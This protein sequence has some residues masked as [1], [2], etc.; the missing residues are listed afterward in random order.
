[1]IDRRSNVGLLVPVREYELAGEGV[2]PFT[3]H[4]GRTISERDNPAGILAVAFPNP[5]E[6][7][8]R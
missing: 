3:E 1:V 6:A 4:S 8:P 2:P 7:E 5:N